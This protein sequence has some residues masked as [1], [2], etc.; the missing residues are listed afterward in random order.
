LSLA[1]QI[2]E[3]L[4]SS[5]T[6]ERELGGGG[7]SKVFV[8]Y[9]QTLERR[10]VVK[11]L[12]P[13][14]MADV[15]AE[16]FR[17]EV[18][19]VAGLQHPHIVPVLSAG[20]IGG[21]P[22]LVMPFVEGESLRTRIARSGPMRVVDAVSVL[23]DVARA[24]AYAHERGIVHRD[25]KPD[26]VL[27]AG[28]PVE[29]R[30]TTA[31]VADFGVAKALDVARRTPGIAQQG[32]LTAAGASLGTPGYMA[33]EQIAADPN[34]DY[35]VDIY[36]FGVTAYEALAGKTPFH[37]RPP[38]A[39]LAAHLSEQPPSLAEQRPDVPPA[40]VSLVMRCLEKDPNKRPK[41]AHE[42]L[43]A[44]DDPAVLSGE[45]SPSTIT[46]ATVAAARNHTRRRRALLVTAF[47]AAIAAAVATSMLVRREPAPPA[48]AVSQK[49][50]APVTPSIAVLPFV[51]LGADS[52]TV[53]AE[54][55]A[56]ELTSAIAR[57]RGVRVASGNAAMAL[58]KRLSLGQNIGDAV[59]MYVEGVVQREGGRVR[60][61][62]RMVNA[63]DGFMVWANSYEGAANQLLALRA[64]IGA[65]VA[66]AVR[67]KLGLPADSAAK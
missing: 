9:D 41:N 29:G 37:G 12:A 17:R 2:R 47:G 45:L 54:A 4:G 30:V 64:Q 51:E 32:T 35:R 3:T 1:E 65:A 22:Y 6:V 27:L 5:F 56:T 61:D 57:D 39:L 24:L 28:Y 42:I 43:A 11:I 21:R 36:A 40:L 48:P 34:A 49:A 14:L 31:V 44:L 50:A 25:I 8:A 53:A 52:T 23:R 46:G 19:V 59:T 66:E 18:L 60:V 26:N 63:A 16:R 20:D 10:V 67:S 33:P 58:Q 7:M 55:I 62:A 13:E 38:H 15:N